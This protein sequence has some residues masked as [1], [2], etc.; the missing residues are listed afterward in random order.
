MF[1]GGCGYKK[2]HVGNWCALTT[3][4]SA[5]TS[6]TLEY[7]A[8]QRHDS[9]YTQEVAKDFKS[10]RSILSV[11]DAFIHFAVAD[12]AHSKPLRHQQVQQFASF[13]PP[14]QPV[15]G[16]IRFDQVT[17]NSTGGRPD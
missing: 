13:R 6:E 14:V 12:Q 10:K 2:V 11:V 15:N 16:P 1:Y 9:D 17:Q 5:F 7:E 4:M 3:Q 8:I